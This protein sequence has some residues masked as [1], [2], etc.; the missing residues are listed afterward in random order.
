MTRKKNKRVK[1]RSTQKP[2]DIVERKQENEE[3]ILLLFK[4]LDL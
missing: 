4:Y 2:G 1:T 3:V